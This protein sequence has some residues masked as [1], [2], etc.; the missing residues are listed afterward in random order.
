MKSELHSK[1]R[2]EVANNMPSRPVEKRDVK[3]AIFLVLLVIIGIIA[4]G[5]INYLFPIGLTNY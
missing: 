5:V 2:Y 1:D 3:L 4:F